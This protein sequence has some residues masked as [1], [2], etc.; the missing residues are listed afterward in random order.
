MIELIKSIKEYNKGDEVVLKQNNKC[1]HCLANKHGVC[2]L[3]KKSEMQLKKEDYD[4]AL[5]PDNKLADLYRLG[6][7]LSK[8]IEAVTDELKSRLD[9]NGECGGISYKMKLGRRSLKAADEVFDVVSKTVTPAEFTSVCSVN[10][11]KMV[12]LLSGKLASIFP[13]KK[14]AK[15]ESEKMLEC[16]MERDSDI[17]EIADSD[18]F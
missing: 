3:F 2:P 9:K 1:N 10:Y 17:K 14:E 15:K 13:T 6:K 8:R 7:S 11:T 4:I 18:K 16:V 12:E 5:L